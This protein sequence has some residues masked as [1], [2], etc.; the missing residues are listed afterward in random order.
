MHEWY[1]YRQNSLLLM[2]ASNFLKM[3]RIMIISV[4]FLEFHPI[5]VMF[6]GYSH[7]TSMRMQLRAENSDS[8]DRKALEYDQNMYVL[9][10]YVFECYQFFSLYPIGLISKYL[11]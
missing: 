5:S 2:Q 4:D 8:I 9:N 6:G 10:E 11:Q 7:S 1:S 3:C